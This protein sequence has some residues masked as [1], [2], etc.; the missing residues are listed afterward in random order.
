MNTKAIIGVNPTLPYSM[1]EAINRLRINVSFFG[2]EIR[3][4]MIVSSEPDEG[5]SLIA[6]HLWQQM[7]RAQER[8][9]LVDVDMRK[10]VMV[11]TYQITRSDGRK[12]WGLTDYLS[13]NKE[14]EDCVLTT[15]MEYGYLLPNVNN[16]VNPS[17]LLESSR[18][19]SLLETLDKE[20]RY[21]FLDTPPLGLVSD[22]ERIGHLCDGAILVVRGGVTPK[23]VIRNSIAQLER[24]GCPLL[25]IV[26]NRVGAGNGRYYGRY[27]GKYYG[28]FY[29]KYY[30]KYYSKYYGR[31][32]YTDSYYGNADSRGKEKKKD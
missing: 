16:I 23:S 15:D 12:L 2:S 10:S 5:K 9:I 4:I 8:S 31:K 32:Q 14:I 26:L 1:E 7:A 11:D 24:A 25:G 3:K 28:R 20:Y 18:F 17:L 29:G 21:I 6:M 19:V 13:D 22:G 27:Y 30:G